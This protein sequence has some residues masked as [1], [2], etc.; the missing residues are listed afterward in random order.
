MS[1]EE[2]QRWVSAYQIL[3]VTPSPRDGYNITQLFA[4][5]HMES[6]HQAHGK[7]SFLPFHRLLLWQFET[8]VRLLGGEYCNFSLPIWYIHTVSI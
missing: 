5:C 6:Q 3:A 1:Y 2:R 7:A 8:Q 4:R